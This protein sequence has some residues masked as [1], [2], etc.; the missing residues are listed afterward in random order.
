[1][2]A[3][4]SDWGIQFP[5]AGSTA[6]DAPPGYMTLYATFFKEGNFRL[7]MSKFLGDVLMRYG[8]HISQVNALGLPR[9]THFEFICRDQ[10]IEPTFEMFNVFYYV[11]YT[12][13]FCSFNSITTGV[14]HCSWDPPKSLH[15][16]KQKFFYIRRGV[17]PIDMHYRPESE[18]VPRVTVSVSFID[19]EWPLL[20]LG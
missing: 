11:T 1:M 18:G 14:L 19:E 8:I 3:F 16:W 13:G 5:T 17:I 2:F 10:K 20:Q 7:A 12:G 9:I 6:L 4:P 15:D